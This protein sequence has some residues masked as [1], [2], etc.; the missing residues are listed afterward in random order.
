MGAIGDILGSAGVRTGSAARWDQ[1]ERA[2]AAWIEE[3]SLDTVVLERQYPDGSVRPIFEFPLTY[4]ASAWAGSP[5]PALH[6]RARRQRYG[7][8]RR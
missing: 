3:Q 2:I 4:N 7:R 5:I 1:D 6:L 8:C